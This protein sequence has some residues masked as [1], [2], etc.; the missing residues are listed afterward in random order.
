MAD[1]VDDIRANL[2]KQIADLRKEMTKISKSVA[3]RAS[4]AMDDAEDA[5]D[6]ARSRASRAAGRVRHQAHVA[7]DLARENPGTTATVITTAALLGL[8]AGL[9]LS[10]VFDGNSRR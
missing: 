2:E 5:F 1:T 10:G 8:A 9:V 4:D 6:E 7:T 3:A